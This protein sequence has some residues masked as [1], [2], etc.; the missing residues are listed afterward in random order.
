MENFRVNLKKIHIYDCDFF[1]HFQ[2]SVNF[3]LLDYWE[4]V[5]AIQISSRALVLF[6]YS[7]AE[8]PTSGDLKSGDP[9]SNYPP[10]PHQIYLHA[11]KST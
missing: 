3:C 5:D 4:D 7:N 8:M 6:M 2:T 1:P 9:V 10:P 11:P